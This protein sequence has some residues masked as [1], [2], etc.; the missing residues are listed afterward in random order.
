M[1]MQVDVGDTSS[2][3]GL[4]R[5]PGGGNRKPL[6]YSCLENPIDRSG[7]MGFQSLW[8]FK[9]SDTTE[10]LSTRVKTCSNLRRLL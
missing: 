1:L 3:C 2:I 7:S 5:S 4:G 9:E 6:W 8:G 10:R